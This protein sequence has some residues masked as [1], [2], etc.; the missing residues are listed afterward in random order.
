[1]FPG[2]GPVRGPVIAPSDPRMDLAR[3]RK[4]GNRLGA[5]ALPIS[6][7]FGTSALKVLQIAAGDVPTLVRAAAVEVPEELRGDPTKRLTFQFK[8]LPRLVKSS[9]FRGK[10][11]VCAIP[12]SHTYCRHVA[13]PRAAGEV[14]AHAAREAIA[15]QL[16]CPSYAIVLRHVDVGQVARAGAGRSEVIAIAAMRELVSKLMES[17]RESSLEPVGMHAEPQALLRAVAPEDPEERDET[18]HATL[19][20]DIGAGGT[21]VIIA[22]GDKLTFARS[23]EFGGRHLDDHIAKRT[24]CGPTKA[25][26]RRLVATELRPPSA[27]DGEG[28]AETEPDARSATAVADAPDAIGRDPNRAAPI[29]LGGA[30]DTLADEISMCRRYHQSMYPDVPVQS[31]VFLGGEARSHALCRHLAE[32]QRLPGHVADPLSR[33]ARSSTTETAGLD[34]SQPQPGWAVP[35]GLCLSP[36]DL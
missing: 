31:L 2:E 18:K 10:R 13:V 25:R 23:F 12:W 36:T 20:L 15:A 16:G 26:R 32:T 3:L 7:D 11:A 29:D 27:P 14:L 33:L 9:G 22:H 24:G 35:L 19:Y 6:V 28:G 8:A 34:L 21:R 5:A 1:M 17:L 4:L 30:I